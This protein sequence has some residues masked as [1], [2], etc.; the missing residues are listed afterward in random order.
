MGMTKRAAALQQF[1]Y[2]RDIS[3]VRTADRAFSDVFLPFFRFDDRQIDIQILFM[4]IEFF[5][6]PAELQLLLKGAVV[7]GTVIR[8]Q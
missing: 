3:A 1:A 8:I 5:A 7:G 4:L 2:F 6:L